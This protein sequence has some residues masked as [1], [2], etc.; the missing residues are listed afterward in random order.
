M[1]GARTEG[2]KGQ[3]NMAQSKGVPGKECQ[4][5]EKNK[6]DKKKLTG[7]GM[8]T[9]M[10]RQWAQRPLGKKKRKSNAKC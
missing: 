1:A 8:Q 7:S 6:E 4:K 5:G 10:G 3:G 9:W 2:A